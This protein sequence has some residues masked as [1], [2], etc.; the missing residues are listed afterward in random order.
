M[1]F[2]GFADKFSAQ[3]GIS[4]LMDDLGQAL[5]SDQPMIM[6]GGGNPGQL[7]PVQQRLRDELLCIAAD[8][9]AFHQL[10]GRYDS[11]QGEAGFITALKDLLNAS[12]GWNL[13]EANIALTNGSQAAFFHAVQSLC[14]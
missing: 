7:E 1:K 5:A 3:A 11:P 13:T 4:S 2:T 9:A 8:P 12:Y 14:R 6:M 10:I